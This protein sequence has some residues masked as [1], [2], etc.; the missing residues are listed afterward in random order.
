MATH[1]LGTPRQRLLSVGWPELTTLVLSVLGLVDSAY[2]TYT[3]YSGTGL[4]GCAAHGDP[5]VVV[6]HSPES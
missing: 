2:Q 1:T 5:C 4:L 6:Q 3:H